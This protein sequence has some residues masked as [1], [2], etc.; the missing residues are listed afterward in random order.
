MT[1]K[2]TP[3]IIWLTVLSLLMHGLVI[4][5]VEFRN[6]YSSTETTVAPLRISIKVPEKTV[7]SP[8]EQATTNRKI[9]RKQDKKVI[10]ARK[11][12]AAGIAYARTRFND[13]KKVFDK[14]RKIFPEQNKP[15][16]KIE[17]PFNT[18]LEAK[19]VQQ[20][21]V[22]DGT[23]HVKI[24]SLFGEYNCFVVRHPELLQ[25]FDHGAWLWQKC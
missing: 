23:T 2:L 21:Q 10:K 11:L 22:A 3:G 24:P 16:K 9:E 19:T 4:W 20:K 13:E 18:L 17:S 6:N 1:S 12:M 25:N 15:R 8:V 7:V 14:R 5:L